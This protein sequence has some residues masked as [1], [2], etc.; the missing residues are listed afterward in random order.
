MTNPIRVAILGATGRM[1]HVLINALRSEPPLKLAAALAASDDPA[2]GQDA[3]SH[4][5]S[6]ELGIH[7]GTDLQ[8][9]LDA[10]DVVVDFSRPDAAIQALELCAAFKK[11]IVTGTTGFSVSEQAAVVNA[12]RRT[13]ICQSANF[14]IGINV[15]LKLLVQA[16]EALGS[17]YDVEIIEAHH[18]SKIDAPSGTALALGRAVAEASNRDLE[19]DAVYSRHGLIGPRDWKSIGFSTIRGGDVVGDHTVLFLG[20]GE[21]IEISHRASSRI[22]FARGAL[23]AAQWLVGRSPGLYDM[24]D[25][26]GFR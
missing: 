22:N 26:L 14:S 7:I 8:A 25:V 9:V 16:T 2:I 1:G 19:A 11:P 17:E 3:G 24:Q 10:C 4:A 18:R 13:A 5:G 15:C 23:R 6:S 12:S 21:R 20:D